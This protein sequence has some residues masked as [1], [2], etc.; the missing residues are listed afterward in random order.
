MLTPGSAG[1]WDDNRLTAPRVVKTDDGY[2]MYYSGSQKNKGVYTSIGMATSTDGIT[3]TKYDNPDTTD[4]LYA[5][6]DP[7]LTT[8]D[9]KE[10]IGQPM[11]QQTP[12]G[13]VMFYRTA[14]GSG[15]G[16]EIGYTISQDGVNW[17]YNPDN[18]FWEVSNI[19][20]SDS[21]WFTAFVYHD[22]TY[23]LYIEGGRNPHTDIYVATRQGSLKD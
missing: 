8:G 16:M 22:D 21:F 15:S 11:V 7:I 9:S 13:W 18:R 19:P 5:E 14:N 3:W 4:A 20:R 12:D 6:S 1:S 23:Y 17:E 2:R 10:F